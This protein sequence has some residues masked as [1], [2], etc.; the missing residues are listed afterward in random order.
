M[1]NQVAPDPIIACRRHVE[2]VRH[3]GRL[4]VA[5]I[6]RIRL[7]LRRRESTPARLRLDYRPPSGIGAPPGS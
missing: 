2:Q 5:L 7:R 4:T 1:R 6:E 3:H